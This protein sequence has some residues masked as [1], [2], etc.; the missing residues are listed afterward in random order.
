MLIL[1]IESSAKA[2]SVALME[3]EKLIAQYSQC[4][5]L[6]HSRTL[7]P[8]IENMLSNTETP[9]NAIDAIAVAQGPGSF[10]GIRIGIS[11]A[12]GLCWGLDIPAVG[13]ST[14]E[15]MAQSARFLSEGTIV[16]PAMDARRSQLYN[17]LF[18]VHN[19]VPVRLTED[20][21][22]AAAALAE[23][24]SGSGKRVWIL[25]DGWAIC[26]KAL[27]ERGVECAVAPEELRW[28]TAFGVCLAAKN[29]T[30]TG[31]EDLLPVYLRLSQAERER[32]S[33]MSEV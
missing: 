4:S 28:Q 18:T 1:A 25:G 10:T 9:K 6:T 15:A 22:I 14:L 19:G 23:E 8:M 11:T 5:G 16:C 2:A 27:K 3:D 13:V 24:L 21:A 31:A 29:K 26:E 33:R 12:K 17:A 32:Q 20:R 30:S 7:L